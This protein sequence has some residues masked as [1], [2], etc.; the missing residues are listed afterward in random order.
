MCDPFV[1]ADPNKQL[2]KWIIKD[3]ITFKSHVSAGSHQ[4]LQPQ[5][6]SAHTVCLV[7]E[8]LSDPVLKS[9]SHLLNNVK[10]INAADSCHA[11]VQPASAELYLFPFSKEYKVYEG[12]PVGL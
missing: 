12:S 10:P 2:I 9:Q 11:R 4:V 7:C 8:P 3:L 6:S 5:W 1:K